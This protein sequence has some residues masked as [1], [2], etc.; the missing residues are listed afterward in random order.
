MSGLKIH[1]G[2]GKRILQGYVNVDIVPREGVDLIAPAS[3]IHLPDGSADEVLAVH[4]FEHIEPWEAPKA[5]A[6]W[7]RLLA[8]GGL[9]VLEM[10]DI[11]KCAQNLL[12]LIDRGDPKQ[13][14]SLAFNGIYGDA[15]LKD[16]WMLH[17]WG[18]TFKTLA[19]MLKEAG[20]TKI[21]EAP[22]QWHPIG[23]AHRDFRIEA[24]KG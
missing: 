11:V 5:L 8:H 19:P 22:T 6:D 18:Y 9:L 2:C 13:L 10:P 17:R 3:R 15:S 16:P 7:H 24:R 4:L 12:K 14:A 21:R 23:K 20:F 1:V